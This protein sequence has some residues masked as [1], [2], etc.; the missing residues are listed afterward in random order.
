MIDFN[1]NENSGQNTQ[2]I[3]T[4]LLIIIALLVSGQ[5]FLNDSRSSGNLLIINEK[6][7]SDS[8]LKMSICS[9]AISAFKSNECPWG[10]LDEDT[11]YDLEN[12]QDL[13]STP[14]R[15]KVLKTVILGDTC[16]VF[17]QD[18][19]PEKG[20]ILR[21]FSVKLDENN[22]KNPWVYRVINIQEIFVTDKEKR[23]YL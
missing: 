3:Q 8:N 10:I 23:S 5:Y 21:G 18:Q 14:G 12:S 19:L 7:N 17:T 2:K 15:F 9:A 11:C 13:I 4:I 20:K 16:K 22:E 6:D 1:N